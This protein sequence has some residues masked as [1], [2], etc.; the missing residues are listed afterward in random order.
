MTSYP[1]PL[2][3]VRNFVT[4]R[5]MVLANTYGPNLS[6]A[7][8][9]ERWVLWIGLEKLEVLVGG[10]SHSFGQSLVERPEAS[11]RAV[12]QSGRDLFALWSAIDSS[13]RRSS[14]PAA[15]SASI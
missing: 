10:R 6:K 12:L 2:H 7:F 14:F 8:E 13:M 9:M 1:K 15:A 5:S 4:E 11:R 3:A